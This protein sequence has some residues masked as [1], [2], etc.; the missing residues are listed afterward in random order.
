MT[1]RER[2][3]RP[4]AMRLVIASGVAVACAAG[5][6]I[7]VAAASAPA[8]VARSPATPRPIDHQLRYSTSRGGYKIPA[9]VKLFNQ[10]SPRGFVP[11][12]KSVP[13]IQPGRQDLADRAEI[14]DH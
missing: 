8:G 10:F 4:A 11:R 13:A 6:M 3:G 9:A 2:R 5:T 12:T 7:G 14:P 1:L